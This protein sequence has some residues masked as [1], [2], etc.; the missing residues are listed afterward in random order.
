[1]SLPPLS[2]V[3]VTVTSSDSSRVA[4]QAGSDSFTLANTTAVAVKLTVK[5]DVDAMDDTV[6]LTVHAGGEIADRTVSVQIHDTDTLKFAVTLWDRWIRRC[7]PPGAQRGRAAQDGR[8][9]DVGDVHRGADGGPAC[10][11]HHGDAGAVGVG[12]VGV[13]P[14][15]LMFTGGAGGTW[16]TP[17]TVT[18]TESRTATWRMNSSPSTCRA[19]ARWGRRRRPSASTSATW[20]PRRSCCSPRTKHETPSWR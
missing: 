10:R 9:Q 1:L 16:Q 15:T 17:Q 18:V 13:S 4:V 7:H 3:A 20:T 2:G 6:T 8:R 19:T 12:V 14:T 5:H 11:H